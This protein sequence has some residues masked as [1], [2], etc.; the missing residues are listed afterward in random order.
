MNKSVIVPFVLKDFQL[1][2]I[3]YTIGLATADLGL[4]QPMFLGLYEARIS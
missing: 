3:L 1:D 4:V 2:N